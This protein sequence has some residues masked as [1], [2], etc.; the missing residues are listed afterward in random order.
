MTFAL[1]NNDSIKK[2]TIIIVCKRAI[3]TMRTIGKVLLKFS[4]DLTKDSPA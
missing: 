1:I 2:A 3:A 4:I